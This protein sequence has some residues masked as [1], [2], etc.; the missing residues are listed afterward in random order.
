MSDIT[1][2]TGEGCPMKDD[3]YRF[4]AKPSDLQSYFETPPFSLGRC[5]YRMEIWAKAKEG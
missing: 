4:K 2:C 3:C 5:E 1:M